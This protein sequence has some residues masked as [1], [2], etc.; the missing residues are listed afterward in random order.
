[1][2]YNY[3][4]LALIG[5]G[6][7]G[8]NLV[9]EFNNLGVLDTICEIND[10]LICDLKKNY[11]HVKITKKWDDV[12]KDENVTAVCVSLPAEMHYKFSKQALLS[13]KDVYVEKPITLNVQEAEELIGLAQE[14]NKILMVGHLLHYHPCIEKIKDVVKNGDIGKVKNIISN[15]LNLGTFRTFENVLWSFAPHDISVVLALCENKLPDEVVCNGKA[16]IT[17]DVHDITNTV[18]K[19]GD[20]YVNINVNWLNPYKEQKMSIIGDKGM[21]LFDDTLKDNKL[22]FFPNYL[23]WS[24][25]IPAVPTPIK[26]VGIPLDYDKKTSPL[27]QE[28]KHFVK[29]CHDRSQP[30]SNGEEGLRVLKVLNMSQESLMNNGQ[31]ITPNI[32]KLYFAHSSAFIDDGANIGAGTKIWHN[33]HVCKGADVGE[34]CSLGQN[35]FVAGGSKLGDGT[36][37]QNNVSVYAGVECGKNVF[38][39]P[40]CVL[41]NDIN[42]RVGYSKGGEYVKTIIKDNVS[43]GANATIR[44]GIVLGAYSFIGCGAVVVKNCDAYGVYVGNP[45]KKIGNVDAEGNR[46]LFK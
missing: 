31:K 18:M 32:K 16:F 34:N 42:P 19:F 8:K 46:N 23:E 12:L 15:R 29:C 9:R 30:I 28:C 37:V 17:K 13:N 21:L 22:L 45:A 39:G 27:H 33:T 35:C 2:I 7:W 10:D 20:V 11:P 36:R 1:M 40:S 44:C 25:T 14:H 26:K 4:K 24:N 6:K 41:T 38:L 43:V 3:M 5:S